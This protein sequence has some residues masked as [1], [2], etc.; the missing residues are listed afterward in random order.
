MFI[1]IWEYH[2]KREK[3]S[4]FEKAY[5]SNGTWAELFNKGSGYLGTELFCDERDRQHYFTLD[6]WDS[7]E[8]YEL[9]QSQFGQEYKALD[10][11]CEGL[12]SSENFLGN[13]NSI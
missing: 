9:F 12:T 13:G 10:L 8:S 7:K 2:V 1:I 3:L 11:Q 6:R 4:E 5:A